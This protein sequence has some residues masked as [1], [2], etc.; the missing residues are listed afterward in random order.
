M[1]AGNS[2]RRVLYQQRK[3]EGLCPRCGN[4]KKKSEKFIYC[5]DCREF[6]RNYN[7]QNSEANNQTRKELYHERKSNRQCPR[8]GKKHGKKYTKIMCEQCLEKQYS[9][10]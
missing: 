1:S 2:D 8:C 7:N 10:T 3:K 9:Y 5:S 6:F 4:K